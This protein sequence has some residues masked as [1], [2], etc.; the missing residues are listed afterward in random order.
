MRRLALLLILLLPIHVGCDGGSSASA[1]ADD[2]AD[3]TG[4]ASETSV[5]DTR[6]TSVDDVA[7]D[8]PA[9]STALDG[10][11]ASDTAGPALDKFGVRE[12]YP[13]AP[14]GREWYLPDTA[15]V[16]DAEWKPRDKIEKTSEKGVFRVT[17][18]PRHDVASPA[19]KAW[20]RNVEITAYLKY[21]GESITDPSQ[22]PHWTFYARGERHTSTPTADPKTINYGVLAPPG[23]AV[24]PGYPYSSG[25]IAQCLGTSIKGAIY[26][27]GTVW[28]KKEISHTEGYTNARGTTKVGKDLKVGWFGHK[29][30][31][32]NF[33]ADKSVHMETWVDASATG[34]WKK[35]TEADDKGGWNAGTPSMNGCTAAPFSYALDQNVTWAGPNVTFR[36]D[37]LIYDFKWASAREIAPLP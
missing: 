7:I 27:D 18:S 20:W 6:D 23:T 9:D 14:A 25:V 4:S 29:V 11:D 1:P 37:N 17:G 19:G 15:D 30:V 34:D 26:P 36:V 5:P 33:G 13:T 32:R 28:W 12:V 24:W 16:A 22:A 8:A 21:V 31:I 3:D 35:V 10:S 2:A